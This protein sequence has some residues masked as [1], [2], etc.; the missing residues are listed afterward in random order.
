MKLFLIINSG[1]FKQHFDTS[2][3]VRKINLSDNFV[4]FEFLSFQILL[5]LTLV[6]LASQESLRTHFKHEDIQFHMNGVLAR[7]DSLL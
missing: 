7:I 1:S 3:I 5:T 6:L 4:N 2:K